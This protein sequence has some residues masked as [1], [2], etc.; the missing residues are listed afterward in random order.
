MI[1]VVG[2]FNQRFQTSEVLLIL[3]CVTNKDQIEMK[4]VRVVITKSMTYKALS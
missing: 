4:T 3:I 2:V 1:G